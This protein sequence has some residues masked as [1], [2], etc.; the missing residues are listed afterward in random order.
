M[1]AATSR[2]RRRGIGA[3]V[4]ALVGLGS[5]GFAGVAQAAPG[6]TFPASNQIGGADRYLTAV[7]AS[8]A[9]FP[10]GGAGA[11]VIVAGGAPAD[12]LTASY[13]AGLNNAPIL[14]ARNGTLTA[15]TAAEV[16][17]LNV[18]NVFL[19]GGTGVL[20]ETIRAEAALTGKTI[21]RYGG[22]DRYETSAAAATNNDGTIA[23]QPGR[24]FIAAGTGLADALAAGPIAYNKDYPILLTRP[25]AVPAATAAALAKFTTANRTVLGGEGAVTPATYTAL[26]ATAR[27]GGASRYETA[28]LVANHA[29]TVEGFSRANLA[30]ANGQDTAAVDSLTGAVVAGR[31][32]VPLL[33]VQTPSTLPTATQAYIT[34]NNAALTGQLYAFGGTNVV[35]PAATQAA[36]TAAT[37]PT[38]FN[39]ITTITPKEA[40][41]LTV[42][43]D[44]A[45]TANVTTDDR[46]YTVTGLTAGTT[47]RITL[48]NAT[49]ITTAADGSVSFTSE[50]VNGA[51]LVAPGADVADITSVNNAAPTFDQGDTALRSTTVQPVAGSIT[52][53]VDGTG[54]GT[55]VPVVYINGGAGGTSTTGGTSP[56][57]ETSATASNLVAGATETFGLGGPTTFTAPLAAGG[58]ITGT[59]VAGVDKA[60]DSFTTSTTANNVTTTVRY[61]Y[62]AGDDFT[63]GGVPVGITAFEAA[64]S[65]GDG[66]TGTF[67]TDPQADS[68]FTLVDDNPPTGATP[69]LAAGTG[70]SSNDVTL[71]V[72]VPGG[73]AVDAV[74]VERAPV[75]NNVAGTYSVIAT[76]TTDADPVA[77][78]FQVRDNDLAAGS[79]SYRVTFINDGD[80][81]AAGTAASITVTAPVNDTTV[82][83]VADTRF[84][85][86]GNAGNPL[87]LETGDVFTLA[88]SEVVTVTGNATLRLRDADGTEVD[89]TNGVSNTTV[90]LSNAP[91]TIGTTTYE[92]GRVVTVTLGAGTQ[93]S[94]GTSAGLSLPATI[95]TQAGLAD[96]AGN[97]L[98]IAGSADVVVD[99]ES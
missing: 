61:T 44:T 68:T 38:N 98:N 10:N 88:F 46:T 50:L 40:A 6:F 27:L 21:T 11:V 84:T 45:P 99:T 33:F 76:A 7:A 90:V 51:Y 12:G 91:T 66:I 56:R 19:V 69:T 77:A 93:L 92:A 54:P 55:V 47:Y 48:V 26:N 59:T 28:V 57:L 53:T 22:A 83:T 8:K 36:V 2:L 80:P 58:A 41:T 72:V 5:I 31:N 43:N 79:Y 42:A 14:Y 89:F 65:A 1:T 74:Q 63:V 67:A 15:E 20:P 94:A 87:L 13:V 34:T 82:P 30:L 52:F 70:A 49:N 3:G 75:T 17:R 4:A 39:S 37:A 23:V 18:P 64:L 62:D 85:A 96:A 81:G 32:G 73:G 9:A 95:T 24:V 16:T 71:T 97:A 78:N 60:T 86:N 35:A 25:N 29:V